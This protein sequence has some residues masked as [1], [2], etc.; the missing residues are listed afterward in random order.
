MR[1]PEK[2]L[3]PDHLARKCQTY[4]FRVH[5]FTTYSFIEK[6]GWWIKWSDPVGK[7]VKKVAKK[8]AFPSHSTYYPDPN[9]SSLLVGDSLM[10]NKQ[11]AS[12]LTLR[13]S[14]GLKAALSASDTFFGNNY[15]CCP[16]SVFK[17]SSET[18]NEKQSWK[19]LYQSYQ[20]GFLA[21]HIRASWKGGIPNL[22]LNL[23]I[24]NWK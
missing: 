4:D 8:Q 23:P 2:Q 18:Q 9:M 13:E 6:P 7:L 11:D 21:T 12:S 14:K 20:K 17:S 1:S 19:S 22:S 10:L 24:V 16:D 15:M 5:N 3:S